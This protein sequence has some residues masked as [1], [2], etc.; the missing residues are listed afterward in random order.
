MS[1]FSKKPEPEKP[2]YIAPTPPPKEVSN[3]VNNS[4]KNNDAQQMNK[5]HETT[6]NYYPDSGILFPALNLIV[7][8]VF[9]SPSPDDD[10]DDGK[11]SNRRQGVV[12]KALV[13]LFDESVIS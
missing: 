13:Y 4:N 10:D 9:Y 2:A 5:T 6:G 11:F 3:N 12:E 7:N 8:E 1:P